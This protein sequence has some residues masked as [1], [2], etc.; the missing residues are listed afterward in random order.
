MHHQVRW[1]GE[2]AR[3]RHTLVEAVPRRARQCALE[4]MLASVQT[5]G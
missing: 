3:M 4:R 2:A 1:V 5:L